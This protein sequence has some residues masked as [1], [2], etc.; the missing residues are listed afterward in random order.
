[1]KITG[2]T[3]KYGN[4]QIIRHASMEFPPQ[5]LTCITGESGSGKSSLLS[6]LGLLQSPTQLESYTLLGQEVDFLAEDLNAQRRNQLIGFIFQE[7]HLIPRLTVFEN[8]ALPLYLQGITS[9]E[10]NTRTVKILEDLAIE[11]H[12]DSYPYQLSGG[13]KQRVCIARALITNPEIILADEPTASL[14]TENTEIIMKILKKLSLH[15]RVILVTHD[16][17]LLA[18]ADGIYEV[19]SQ[20]V[21]LTQSYEKK[22]T[23]TNAI[24]SIL[25]RE[26][27][28]LR[29]FSHMYRKK[30]KKQLHKVMIPL[31][32]II[33]ALGSYF[34]MFG[35]K[36]IQTQQELVSFFSQN[37]ISIVKRD[38]SAN[39]THEDVNKNFT[40]DELLEI[41]QL[42]GIKELYEHHRLTT[43]GYLDPE[44]ES[45]SKRSLI[46]S[47]DNQV[48]EIDY[49]PLTSK[50]GLSQVDLVGK[51]PT[52]DFSYGLL[53]GDNTADFI[54]SASFLQKYFP[55]FSAKEVI[56]KT[57]S[58]DILVPTKLFEIENIFAHTKVIGEVPYYKIITIEKTIGAIVDDS[59]I[60]L[61]I[62]PVEG[63]SLLFLPYS[64][65][66]TLLAENRSR[67]IDADK[68]E[69]KE[70]SYHAQEIQLVTTDTV[71]SVVL[72]E[73][74]KKL[75]KDYQ[76]IQASE[77]QKA[78]E[79]QFKEI[80]LIALISII[81]VGVLILIIY[82]VYYSMLLSK[83]KK[84]FGLLKVIGLSQ[85][86]LFLLIAWELS[87]HILHIWFLSVFV[88]LCLNGIE[89]ILLSGGGISTS[90]YFIIYNFI[91]ASL[92][93]A[94][95]S[96]PILWKASKTEATVLI[97][98]S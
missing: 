29:Q 11:N 42:N 69:F 10:I 79:T 34:S 80:R 77:A 83:R 49:S 64:E 85:R 70:S 48:I 23:N 62:L 57:M 87:Y 60:S 6:I 92:Y 33:I 43:V 88:Q 18:Y 86:T 17:S 5:S 40:N 41:A 52:Q 68:E 31:L 90:F 76:V 26:K 25:L 65:I 81:S 66:Q 58:F 89:F 32:A 7:F 72:V 78:L 37:S 19:D 97:S 53:A 91:I 71:D 50:T 75:S 35:Q 2:L 22:K 93:V 55:Q 27:P 56:G 13:E 14:D 84:E 74:L 21:L 36:Y 8:I 98:K 59:K 24:E 63:K 45:N 96:L 38:F 51:V 30:T 3:I 61:D 95:P 12:C 39:T 46:F 20:Q 94:I 47:L 9:D 73:Q 82:L 54:I 44:F 16:R 15:K 28:T 4:K 67:H 1:M